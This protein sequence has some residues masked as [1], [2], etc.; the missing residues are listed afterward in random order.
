[1]KSYTALW[2]TNGSTEVLFVASLNLVFA[3]ACQAQL[4]KDR[5]KYM[6]AG[7]RYFQRAMACLPFTSILSLGGVK[8]IQCLLLLAQYAQSC[9]RANL[10]ISA[11]GLA[12]QVSHH[13]HDLIIT[14]E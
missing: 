8:V 12:I 3:S 1:M 2:T 11:T 9:S 6:A 13:L 5:D 14:H 10:C 7:A 4:I